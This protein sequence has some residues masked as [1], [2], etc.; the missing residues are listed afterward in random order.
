M[1]EIQRSEDFHKIWNKLVLNYYYVCLSLPP[2]LS[3][4]FILSLSE[5]SFVRSGFFLKYDKLWSQTN[6]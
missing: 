2:S 6:L 3:L 5:T 1:T 4:S